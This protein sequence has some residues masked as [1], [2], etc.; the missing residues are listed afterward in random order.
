MVHIEF[1]ISLKGVVLEQAENETLEDLGPL[2]EPDP[3]PFSFSTPGWYVL[4]SLLLIL[5]FYVA[6]KRIKK[7]NHNAYRR[8][9]LG[10]VNQL[11]NSRADLKDDERLSGLLAQLKIVAVQSY[12]R[13]QVAS[14]N[15]DDWWLFLESTGNNT[16]FSQYKKVISDSVYKQITP[17]SSSMTK[18]SELTKRWIK[19]HA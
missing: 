18:I 8:K 3:I 11:L 14:M 1:I 16:P 10:Q 4:G 19:T 2:M 13:V 6:F 7:Y 9:A 12:G 17:D 15:G 5:V